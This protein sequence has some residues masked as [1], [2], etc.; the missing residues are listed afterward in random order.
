MDFSSTWIAA[1]VG[2]PTPAQ[3]M[4]ETNFAISTRS[5]LSANTRHAFVATAPRQVRGRKAG[6]P[7]EK[8]ARLQQLRAHE[9]RAYGVGRLHR[10][11]GIAGGAF[12]SGDGVLMQRTEFHPLDRLEVGEELIGLGDSRN[13]QRVTVQ[14]D[15]E[16]RTQRGLGA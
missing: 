12:Q 16:R 15:L 3:S 14:L 5:L 4:V 13:R 10:E 2:G 11:H 9:Q 8:N 7:K 6:S 1:S